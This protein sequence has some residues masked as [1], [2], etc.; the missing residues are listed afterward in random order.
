VCRMSQSVPH[1]LRGLCVRCSSSHTT[2]SLRVS[3]D[4][5]S[6][7]KSRRNVKVRRSSAETGQYELGSSNSS[8]VTG[9]CPGA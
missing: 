8:Q 3:F 4:K 5:L 9:Y 7:Q 1:D 2:G 6:P